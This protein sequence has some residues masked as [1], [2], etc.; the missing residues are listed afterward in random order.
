MQR[1]ILSTILQSVDGVTREGDSTR[2]KDGYELTVFLGEPGRT[3]VVNHVQS[4][5][6]FATHAVVEARDRGKLYVPIDS[7][8]ALQSLQAE[9]KGGK[10][11]GVGF[12]G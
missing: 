8:C 3:M 1:D 6:L 12:S 11:G 7:V 9:Q 10:R 2:T 4:V 5:T